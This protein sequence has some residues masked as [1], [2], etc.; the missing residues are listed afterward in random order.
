MGNQKLKWTT[1]EEEALKAGVAKHGVGKWKN[2]LVDSQFAHK[3][4]NRSN[5]DLKDKWR[6]LGVSHGQGYRDNTM[7]PKG[8]ATPT[9]AA[10]PETQNASSVII[11]KDDANNNPPQSPQ[12]DDNNLNYNAMIIEALSS[13]KDCSGSD[14]GAIVGFIEVRY[15]IVPFIITVQK[16]Y[17]IKD[18]A[19]CTK[20]PIPK[21]KD[22]GPSPLQKSRST[23][24]TLEDAAEMAAHKLA[25]AENKS[26]IAAEAVKESERVSQMAEE[27]DAFFTHLKEV[28]GQWEDKGHNTSYKRSEVEVILMV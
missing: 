12:D 22:I 21:Q 2:I 1:E 8:K 19:F 28:F 20:T 16:R 25:E 6:N 24:E 27:A 15:F 17:K 13:I 7:T 14:F 26:F 5:V 9:V 3:L 23:K 11:S 18:T 10:A 4:T